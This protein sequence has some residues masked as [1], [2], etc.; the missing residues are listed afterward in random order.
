MAKTGDLPVPMHIRNAPT[1]MMKQM[2]YGDGYAYAHSYENNFIVQ[3]FLPDAIKGTKFYEPGNNPREE[4]LRKY[5]KNL[6]KEKYNY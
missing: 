3:E 1:K 6:W 2:G 5:L 4:E